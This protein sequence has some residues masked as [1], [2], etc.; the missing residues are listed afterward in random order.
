MLNI[1]TNV[2]KYTNMYIF[3]AS[4]TEFAQK[5][6]AFTPNTDG[7]TW[8]ARRFAVTNQ[9]FSQ[10]NL[11]LQK[12]NIHMKSSVEAKS[13]LFVFYHYPLS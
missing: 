7:Q 9:K 3:H 10:C 12:H 4:K 6:A 11:P 5:C 2:E 1:T 8:T 13:K